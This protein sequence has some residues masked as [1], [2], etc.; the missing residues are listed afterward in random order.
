MSEENSTEEAR[1]KKLEELRQLYLKQ[2]E[3]EQRKSDTEGQMQGLLKK[4]LDED[5]RARLNN[6]RLVNED[7]YAKAFQAIM[8]LVQRGFVKQ[9]LK[10]EQVK[11]ILRQL[12]KNFIQT[13]APGPRYF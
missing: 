7:L 12:T 5:A 3:E 9:K 8:G 13:T 4:F 10:E 2:Q 1:Q 6:V 11:E